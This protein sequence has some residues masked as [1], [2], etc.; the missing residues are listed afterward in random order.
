MSVLQLET[1]N[2]SNDFGSLT[3]PSLSHLF[4][5]KMTHYRQQKSSVRNVDSGIF[6]KFEVMNTLSLQSTVFILRNQSKRNLPY[7]V[8]VMCNLKFILIYQT[9]QNN[10]AVEIL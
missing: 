8:L 7:N 3:I 6:L 5:W 4:I 9:V 2:L 1:E 10:K